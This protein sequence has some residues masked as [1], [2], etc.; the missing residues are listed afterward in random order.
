MKPLAFSSARGFTLLEVMLALAVFAVV[1]GG[2]FA[3]VRSVLQ[4]TATMREA[5]HAGNGL[6]G[7]FE[8]CRRTFAQLPAAATLLS[9]SY[10][11][12]IP[13]PYELDIENAPTAFTFGKNDFFYGQIAVT[14]RQD[15]KGLYTFGVEYR[16][17]DPDTG[18]T[19]D[20]P[21]WVPLLDGLK[22]VRWSYYSLAD[23][24]WYDT[25][26]DNA[27]PALVAL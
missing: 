22:E 5:Q 6:N 27:R 23:Q 15:D 11:G 13:P 8:L 20:D 24:T 12:A 3:T 17:L 16:R 14:A 2:L 25:W 4:A 19:L 7:A 9:A 18:L 1:A 10:N 26:T 21:L